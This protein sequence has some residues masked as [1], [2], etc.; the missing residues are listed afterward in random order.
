[1][2]KCAFLKKKKTKTNPNGVLFLQRLLLLKNTKYVT[3]D[4]N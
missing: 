2:I 4:K 3:I 1:M